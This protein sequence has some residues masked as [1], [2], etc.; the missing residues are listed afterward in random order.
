MI[1][2]AHV[3]GRNFRDAQNDAHVGAMTLFVKLGVYWT[4]RATQVANTP[5][6]VYV[7]SCIAL[8]DT[9][10]DGMAPAMSAYWLYRALQAVTAPKMAGTTS[11]CS[12]VALY[13]FVRSIDRYLESTRDFDGAIEHYEH[14]ETH[15]SEVRCVA[16]C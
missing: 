16:H 6:L 14:S 12:C 13:I 1:K 8:Y 10:V 9:Q 7:V 15:R 5:F 4:C 3:G 2:Y 11:E